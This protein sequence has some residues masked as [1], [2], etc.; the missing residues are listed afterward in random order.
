MVQNFVGKVR[1]EAEDEL[2]FNIAVKTHVNIIR[3]P[4]PFSPTGT[5]GTFIKNEGGPYDVLGSSNISAHLDCGQ[6]QMFYR[7]FISE[8]KKSTHA[9]TP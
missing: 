3:F 9:H 6:K 7:Q 2:L 1:S 4:P 8:E 5:W